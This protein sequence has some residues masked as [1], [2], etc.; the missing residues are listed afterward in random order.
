MGG[1]KRV[2]RVL[3]VDDQRL[4]RDGLVTL[5]NMEEDIQVVGT[6]DNGDEAVRCV[7]TQECDVVLM[8]IR[9]PVRNG[10]AATRDIVRLNPAVKVLMLTTYEE[11]DDVVSA[12]SAGAVGYLLK[13]MPAEEIA[14]SIRIAYNGG[15]V[16]PPTV[17]KTFLSA[18][19]MPES[20]PRPAAPQPAAELESL[21]ERELDV[22]HCLAK[23]MS[24]REI[25]DALHVTEGTVKN[26]VSSLIAKLNLRDRTQV[27]LFAVRN[28]FGA[29]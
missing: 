1:G 25:A 11:R 22:L 16:L 4:M 2:I 28:G 18:V 5:L 14:E 23:G 21:T 17:A 29:N 7:Q 13:D 24:N 9:M 8:D 26:H 10:I 15:A 3:V 27:A 12:L 20:A 6:A 19:Q